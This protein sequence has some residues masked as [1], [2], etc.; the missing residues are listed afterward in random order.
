MVSHSP[1][2]LTGTIAAA[3]L[4]PQ[5][6]TVLRGPSCTSVAP[7]TLDMCKT[8]RS[9]PTSGWTRRSITSISPVLRTRFSIGW[10]DQFLV[11][12]NGASGGSP[13]DPAQFDSLAWFLPE[14]LERI[15][16]YS[17][18]RVSD[19][20][21]RLLRRPPNRTR[22]TAGVRAC[23]LSDDAHDRGRDGRLPLFSLRRRWLVSL[24]RDLA[25]LGFAESPP[26]IQSLE[27]TPTPSP[28]PS[29]SPS[30]SGTPP[31]KVLSGIAPRLASFEDD[32]RVHCQY[33]SYHTCGNVRVGNQTCAFAGYENGGRDQAYA[34][35]PMAP[36]SY[37]I[38][39]GTVRSANGCPASSV[40][41]GSIVVE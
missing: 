41:I 31:W 18:G 25:H 14:G 23:T 12:E 15:R 20:P 10:L 8:T 24:D 11:T 29:P 3:G 30:Q 5:R 21:R 19:Q 34:C 39:C 27:L 16:R 4:F 26:G 35:D 13:I 9:G 17:G 22:S 38:S 37:L 32:F 6:R 40:S 28:T 7:M 1:P 2:L 33:A 36:G